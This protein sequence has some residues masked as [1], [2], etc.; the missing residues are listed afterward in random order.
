MGISRENIFFASNYLLLSGS[1]YWSTL[2]LPT[3]SAIE[4]WFDLQSSAHTYNA[5]QGVFQH[6]LGAA[7]LI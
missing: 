3:L 1:G 6:A 7:S 2:G 5:G 4:T